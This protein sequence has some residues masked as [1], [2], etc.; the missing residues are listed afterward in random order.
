MATIKYPNQ[1]CSISRVNKTLGVDAQLAIP[2]VK[3]GQSPLEMHAG[4]SRFIL[5]ILEAVNG[6]Y[7]FVS[8]NIAAEEVELIKFKTE[9]AV[10]TYLDNSMNKKEE[11]SPAYTTTFFTGEFK[12]KTP[13]M[14]LLENPANKTKLLNF[15]ETLTANLAKF[16]RNKAQITAIEEAIQ[17]MDAGKLSANSTPVQSFDI[18]RADI[19][20]PHASKKDSEGLTD[21]YGISICCDLSRNYPFTINIM[22]CKA[23]VK[24]FPNGTQAPDMAKAKYKKESNMTLTVEEWYKTINKMCNTVKLFEEMNFAKMYDV[25][26]DASY[27]GS[28][29]K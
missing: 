3:N 14:V 12:S 29:T 26:K 11:I 17:L 19:R 25:M 6:K 8:A 1:I 24:A 22:T 7:E 16:P 13:A 18:Y 5:T 21:V 23:P 9:L 4:Y 10:K 2:D 20:M 15:K 28:G 27:F